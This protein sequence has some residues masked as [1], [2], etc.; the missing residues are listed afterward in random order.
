MHEFVTN[1]RI[2]FALVFCYTYIIVFYS[3]NVCLP[4]L[5]YLFKD[6]FAVVKES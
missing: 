1:V 2:H 5:Y 3:C 6:I 4:S